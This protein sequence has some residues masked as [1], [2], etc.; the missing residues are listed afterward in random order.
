[1]TVNTSERQRVDDG[2]PC[3]LR[4]E[5][6]QHETLGTREKGPTASVTKSRYTKCRVAQIMKLHF[7][8]TH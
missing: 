2:T 5:I 1:M 8:I 6:A 4:L 7:R 3:R